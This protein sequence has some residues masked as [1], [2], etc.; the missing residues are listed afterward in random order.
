V[1][2]KKSR[3]CMHQTHS[4]M[5]VRIA[6]ALGQLVEMGTCNSARHCLCVA[7]P[8]VPSSSSK[9][10]DKGGEQL[11]S[12]PT[13]APSNSSRAAGVANEAGVQN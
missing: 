5:C 2:S 13:S 6:H 8:D 3:K 10:P 1:G 12:C 9:G 7:G 4:S 11:V